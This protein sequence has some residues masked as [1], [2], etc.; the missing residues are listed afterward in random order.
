MTGVLFNRYVDDMSQLEARR[1]LMYAQGAALPHADSA[2]WDRMVAR[3]L[4]PAQAD[5]TFFR[6]EG[7]PVRVPELIAALSERWGPAFAA[8]AD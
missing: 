4:P 8:E 3:S 5:E 1:I 2:A 7:R 6:Y